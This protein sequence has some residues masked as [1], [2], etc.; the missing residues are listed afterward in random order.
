MKDADLIFYNG[1]IITCSTPECTPVAEAIAICGNKILAIGPSQ[2]ILKLSNSNTK[3]YDLKGHSVVPG[4][5][6]SHTH[7]LAQGQTQLMFSADAMSE[8]EILENA[9]R[10]I[11]DTAPGEWVEGY[12][13]F[14]N[15]KWDTLDPAKNWMPFLLRIHCTFIEL[16]DKVEFCAPT[17]ELWSWQ[18]FPKGPNCI[19]DMQCCPRLRKRCLW[20]SRMIVKESQNARFLRHNRKC[21]PMV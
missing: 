20:Q 4:M 6:D 3:A 9:K 12:C 17:R 13:G 1:R 15:S 8:D 21:F 16:P 19:V 11:L 5:Y 18:E 2:E 7:L 10:K 14:R